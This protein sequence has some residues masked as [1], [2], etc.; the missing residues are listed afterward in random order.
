MVLSGWEVTME[1]LL[2]PPIGWTWQEDW[3][4]RAYCVPGTRLSLC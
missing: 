2:G 1:V 4:M 3:R